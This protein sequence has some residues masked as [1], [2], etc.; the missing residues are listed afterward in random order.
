MAEHRR[1]TSALIVIGNEILS[2]RTK[3]ANL[4]YL[5]DQLNRRGIVLAEARVV[6]DE[7]DAIVAAVNA[8]RAA[9]DYVF[10]TGGIGPTHD[11]I[12]A[13]AVAAAFGRSLIRHPEAEAMLRDFY[14]RTGRELT[15]A[16]LKMA[17]TPEGA[18]LIE[19]RIST[20]PGFQVENVFVLAGIPSVM[21]A[22]F[23]SLA[24]RLEGG[25]EVLSRTLSADIPEG[26]IAAGLQVLQDAFPELEIGSYPYFQE[27]RPG[28][29]IVVRGVDQDKLDAAIERLRRLMIELG[30][31]PVESN[32]AG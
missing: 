3:D 29:S 1:V 13:A 24:D 2:G 16:R 8:C 17:D 6:R 20:A 10:T 32:R 5:A 31:E 22:M 9:F 23:E 26:T 12:T 14:S 27:G 28:A 30:G 4:P 21:Q 7:T 25:A 15:S 18:I 19:N 11:D